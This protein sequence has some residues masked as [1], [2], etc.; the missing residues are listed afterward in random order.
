VIALL[1][2]MAVAFMLSI[3]GTPLL[4][5]PGTQQHRSADP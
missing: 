3:F 2:G 1:V 4:I 5:G